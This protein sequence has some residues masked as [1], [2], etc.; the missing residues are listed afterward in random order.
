[1][2]GRAVVVVATLAVATGAVAGVYV[3]V[4]AIADALASGGRA[5]QT[6]AG[7]AVL[8][9][10]TL[11]MIAATVLYDRAAPPL[12]PAL[13]LD[14]LEPRPWNEVLTRGTAHILAVAVILGGLAIPVVSAGPAQAQPLTPTTTTIIGYGPDQPHVGDA[15]RSPSK[16]TMGRWARS[17]STRAPPSLVPPRSS[18]TAS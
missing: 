9:L 12:E 5:P 4:R 6:A 1:M 14:E 17:P 10:I 2:Q 18:T 16:W 11:P 15:T 7:V 13:V 3:G 8:A